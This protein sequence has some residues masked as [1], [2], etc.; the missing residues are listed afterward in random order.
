M[1]I[2]RTKVK[3][4]LIP[5]PEREYNKLKKVLFWEVIGIFFVTIIGSLFHFM[6][7]WLGHWAPL[8]GFFP[9]NE[10]VWEHLKLPFWSL[11]VFALIEYNFIK[12]YSNNLVIAKIIASLISIATILIVFYSYTTIFKIELLIVDIFSFIFGVILGQMASYKI[13]TRKKFSNWVIYVSWAT[14]LILALAFF[15]FTYFPPNISI[16]Q[17][18]ATGLYGI[19]DHI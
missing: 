14:M 16:F 11:L 5:S 12:N 1:N 7:E 17:D 15:L 3:S 18:S 19:L 8:G 10:S 6:F 9:V 13:I 4:D 2:S